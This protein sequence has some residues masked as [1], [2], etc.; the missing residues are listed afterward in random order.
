MTNTLNLSSFVLLEK[1]NK[2]LE[3]I[4]SVIED[5]EFE[6]VENA[7]KIFLNAK[8][9]YIEDSSEKMQKYILKFF[10]IFAFYLITLIF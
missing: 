7:E 10:V 3:T 5:D 8:K 6:S 9:L 1:I 4:I 2:D